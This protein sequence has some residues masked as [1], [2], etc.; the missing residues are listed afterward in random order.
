MANKLLD[1]QYLH[2]TQKL[3]ITLYKAERYCNLLESEKG[4]P[5]LKAIASDP[6]P[7]DH[8]KQLTNVI[9]NNYDKY[10]NNSRNKNTP[11]LD[12]LV[13]VQNV[14]THSHQFQPVTSAH[15]LEIGTEIMLIKK[16][17]IKND[18]I[19]FF[20]NLGYFQ[21]STQPIIDFDPQE[22]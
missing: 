8:I 5:L 4:I 20:R 10:K 13:S 14:E 9:L 6:R 11:M 1:Y 21:I 18:N 15:P 19:Y 17:D 2:F 12:N 7:Y 16:E 22:P 3:K